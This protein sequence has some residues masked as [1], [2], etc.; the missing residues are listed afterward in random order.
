MLMNGSNFSEDVKV[1][2]K[3]QDP[4]FC[5]SFRKEW[6]EITSVLKNIHEQAEVCERIRKEYESYRITSSSVVF[7]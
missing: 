1:D 6:E 2:T 3:I 4:V 5:N 7:R